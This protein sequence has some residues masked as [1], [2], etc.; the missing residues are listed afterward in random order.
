MNL[1]E[2]DGDG[3]DGDGGGRGGGEGVGGGEKGRIQECQQGQ[4]KC[5]GKDTK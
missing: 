2:I 3:D 4:I 5:G 1:L